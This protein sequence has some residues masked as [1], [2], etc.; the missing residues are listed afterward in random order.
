MIIFANPRYLWLLLLI[1]FFFLGLALWMRARRRE[2]RKF[3][4]EDLVNALMPSWSM[5]VS[6]TSTERMELYLGLA[7]VLRSKS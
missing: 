6:V 5:L 7:T 4:E 1:P 2:L 3:G